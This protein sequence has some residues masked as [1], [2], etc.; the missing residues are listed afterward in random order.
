MICGKKFFLKE[1]SHNLQHPKCAILLS[2]LFVCDIFFDTIFFLI[3][4]NKSIF[5]IGVIT[6]RSTLA[7][8]DADEKKRAK[9]KKK[10]EKKKRRRRK[11]AASH[12]R[13][14]RRRVLGLGRKTFW[15]QRWCSTRRKTMPRCFW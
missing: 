9:K 8:T 4:I 6:I 12:R 10:K 3:K 2:C 13:T 5:L 7:S 14:K 11:L 15:G 1:G